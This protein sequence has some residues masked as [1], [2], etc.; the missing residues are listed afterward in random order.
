MGIIRLGIKGAASPREEAKDFSEIACTPRA[1]PERNIY[2][3]RSDS[4]LKKDMTSN[5]QLNSKED[6]RRIE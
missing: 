4:D 1:I 6:S 2:C 5:E 3:G